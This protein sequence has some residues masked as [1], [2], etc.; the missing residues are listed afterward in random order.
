MLGNRQTPKV[1]ASSES[2]AREETED[3]ER[4]NPMKIAIMSIAQE[5]EHLWRVRGMV[6]TELSIPAHEL[7]CR[8]VFIEITCGADPTPHYAINQEIEIGPIT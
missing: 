2:E 1:C 6:L 5:T 3:T 4:H 8:G 7:K